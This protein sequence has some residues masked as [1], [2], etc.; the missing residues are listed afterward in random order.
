MLYPQSNPYRSELGSPPFWNFKADPQKIG[1]N[2][3]WSGG[4]VPDAEIAIPGSWNEQLEEIGLFNYIGSAWCSCSMFIPKTFGGGRTW[5]R[6][7]SADYY[8]K[9]WVNGEYV[10]EHSGGF[11]PFEFDITKNVNLGEKNRITIL[12]NNELT[13]ETIPQGISSEDFAQEGRL[14]EETFPPA[15][16]DF[17]PYGGIHRPVAIYSTPSNYISGLK[18]DTSVT[19]SKGVVRIHA[20][21]ANSDGMMICCTIADVPGPVAESV[22][23]G[24][25]AE[26]SIE[27]ERCRFWSPGDPHLYLLHAEL[28]KDGKIVDAY[29]TPVG[30]RQISIVDGKLLLN[31]QPIY[32]TGFGRHEDFPVL[33]KAL[34]APL[35]VKDFGLMKWVNANSFRTSHYP[36]ADEVMA[37]ADRQGFLVI[38]EVPAVSL[39]LRYTNEKTIE[40]HK[41]AIKDLIERDCNHPSVVMWALG[42]EP[43]LVGDEGYHKGSGKKYWEEIFT[44]ARTLDASRP[45]TVPNCTRAG[46]CDPVFEFSDILSINR[47]YGWYE[48]PGKIEHGV[49]VLEAEMEKI[50]AQYRK[51][52]MMTEF[53]ADTMPGLHSISDQMFTEEYQEELLEQ[54][55]KLLRS[56]KYVVGEHVWNFADF[57]TPQHFRRILLNMK[58]VFTR[59]RQP[60]AA[61]FK[62]K[63]LWAPSPHSD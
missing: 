24:G 10:G 48:Y 3:G 17:F 30:V 44:F 28:I 50:Y 14:R 47:Y 41:Q 35:I 58:G 2:S 56:K 62:L 40:A 16:F 61:A 21:A 6:I 5:L 32:L 18:V 26:M 7:G 23:A 31:G 45:M 60:K 54:Y 29:E 36:Y 20:S 52:M 63:K 8:A 22:V 12:V 49:N 27:I 11:L 43:N 25:K 39:D 42:N 15:R 4:F 9:V 33:G 55:I 37:M 51:P 13:A 57:R 1:E 19:G 38:D 46:S 59:T 53:G 34:S